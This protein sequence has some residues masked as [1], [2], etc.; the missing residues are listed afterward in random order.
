MIRTKLE[1]DRYDSDE[2]RKRLIS[3]GLN[4]KLKDMIRT[5]LETV[6]YDLG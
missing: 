2:I 1:R 5:I 3:F 4:Q 6:G